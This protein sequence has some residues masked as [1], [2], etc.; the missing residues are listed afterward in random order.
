MVRFG[1]HHYTDD[2]PSRLAAFGAWI[3]IASLKTAKALGRIVLI[4][5]L[6]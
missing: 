2:A 1:R 6:H 3:P 4:F 5:V